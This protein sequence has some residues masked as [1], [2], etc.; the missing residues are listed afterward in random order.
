[1]RRKRLDVHGFGMTH[2]YGF[3]VAV[4]SVRADEEHGLVR[5]MVGFMAGHES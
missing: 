4:A 2:E 3:S 1:M 5:T